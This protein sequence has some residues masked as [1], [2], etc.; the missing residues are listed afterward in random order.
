[1]RLLQGMQK[2]KNRRGKANVLH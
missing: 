2:N 1:M